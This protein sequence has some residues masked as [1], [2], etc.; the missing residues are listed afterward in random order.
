[1]TTFR[2]EIAEYFG[3]DPET[4]LQNQIKGISGTWTTYVHGGF[5]IEVGGFII[6]MRVAFF[7]NAPEECGILGRE[8]F[9]DFFKVTFDE[10]KRIVELK[11][12]QD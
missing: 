2:Y 11:P 8:G 12:R 6:P 1:M 3:I 7:K 5:E 10:A 4:G 9:F